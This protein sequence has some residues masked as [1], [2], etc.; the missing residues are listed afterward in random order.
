MNHHAQPDFE[1]NGR[2]LVAFLI[3]QI[4][5]GPFINDLSSEKIEN[6]KLFFLLIKVNGN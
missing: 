6:D 5:K 1:L 2:S 4:Q 3:K